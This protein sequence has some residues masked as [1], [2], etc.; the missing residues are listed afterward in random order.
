MCCHRPLQKVLWAL[1]FAKWAYV[2]TR[3]RCLKGGRNIK[4]SPLLFLILL[5]CYIDLCIYI[6][7]QLLCLLPL[8][9]PLLSF[10]FSLFFSFHLS[11]AHLSVRCTEKN[12]WPPIPYLDG[13]HGETHILNMSHKGFKIEINYP[14]T[15]DIIYWYWTDIDF[16]Q[17]IILNNA[18][19]V[20]VFINSEFSYFSPYHDIF[21]VL[22]G[23][24][25]GMSV[26][27]AWE[28]AFMI[29]ESLLFCM[30][31]FI[32]LS[33]HAIWSDSFSFKIST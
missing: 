10:S 7:Y 22:I 32:Y 8:F 30:I 28:K 19:V 21:M 16:N 26:D 4:D 5:Y 3:C 29:I 23:L 9:P 1:H 11:G 12:S 6:L 20:F 15:F 13:D 2:P 31:C 17:C 18:W 24:N 25:F 14:C 27:A 33:L